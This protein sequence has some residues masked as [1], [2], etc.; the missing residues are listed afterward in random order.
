MER[1]PGG[2]R[3]ELN[4][5]CFEIV[6]KMTHSSVVIIQESINTPSPRTSRL[7][8]ARPPSSVTTSGTIQP[9][10]LH[11]RRTPDPRPHPPRTTDA[12]ASRFCF[13]FNTLQTRFLVLFSP[14]PLCFVRGSAHP[15]ARAP[16]DVL[17]PHTPA[18]TLG[19]TFNHPASPL[20]NGRHTGA[21]F[22]FL[23]L[24]AF[25]VRQ[26][27]PAP[28]PPRQQRSPWCPERQYRSDHPPPTQHT[29]YRGNGLPVDGRG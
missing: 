22:G 11:L 9:L 19:G 17:Q 2:K 8:F 23:F 7:P 14:S 12:P 20:G 6:L 15:I 29:L 25:Q 21:D 24:Q 5:N 3:S 27:V 26:S 16:I 10:R 28:S 1:R 13:V 4:S 18:C